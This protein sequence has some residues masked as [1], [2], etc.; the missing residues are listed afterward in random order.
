MTLRQTYQKGKMLLEKAGIET[1]VSGRNSLPQ[2]VDQQGTDGKTGTTD[3]E[4]P[5]WKVPAESNRRDG[6]HRK[7]K[8]GLTYGCNKN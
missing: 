3:V 2:G 7:R 4:E 5:V 8:S 6:T 1:S